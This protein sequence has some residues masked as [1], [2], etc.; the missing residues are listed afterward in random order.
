MDSQP[1]VTRTLMDSHLQDLMEDGEAYGWLVVRDFH[2]TWLQYIEMG[3]ATWDDHATKLKLRRT[4]VWHRVAAPIQ[5][6]SPNLLPKTHQPYHPVHHFQRTFSSAA[7]HNDVECDRYNAGQ[8]H[9]NLYHEDHLHVCSY[10]QRTV[11]RL[12]YHPE[13]HC[14]A[15]GRQK[16]GMGKSKA[17]SLQEYIR[18]WISTHQVCT[19]ARGPP[20][21]YPSP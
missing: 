11:R 17:G 15:K 3:R 8:C 12:C 10:C 21:L 9:D 19:A 1:Q 20:N 7:H 16:M 6:S 5:G 18:C 13:V 14:Q 4:L 2:S